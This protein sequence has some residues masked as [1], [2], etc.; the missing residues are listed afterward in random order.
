MYNVPG[1][2][3]C[4]QSAETTIKLAKEFPNKIIGIKE[5]AA[6]LYKQVK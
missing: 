6:I 1:R 5:Q 4:N 3:G 2:T